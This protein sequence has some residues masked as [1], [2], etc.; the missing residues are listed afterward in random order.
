MNLRKIKYLPIVCIFIFCQTISINAMENSDNS[1]KKIVVFAT[2]TDCGNCLKMIGDFFDM[3]R[4]T[5]K[6]KDYNIVFV[7]TACNKTKWQNLIKFNNIK[8]ITKRNEIIKNYKQYNKKRFDPCIVIY[9]K[10]DNDIIV[11]NLMNIEKFLSAY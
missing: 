9:N 10:Y 4:N 8:Y 1:V 3:L 2:N 11:L 6:Y 5:D 7:T